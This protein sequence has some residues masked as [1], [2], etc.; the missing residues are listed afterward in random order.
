MPSL[1]SENAFGFKGRIYGPAI[2]AFILIGFYYL[3][4]GLK[5]DWKFGVSAALALS[6]IAITTNFMNLGIAVGMILLVIINFK[7]FF[8]PIY[9]SVIGILIVCGIVYLQSSLVP[10]LVQTKLKYVFRPWEYSSLRIRISDLQKAFRSENFTTLENI[11]GKGFGASTRI[12][13]DNKI[14]V[15]FRGY[16]TFQEI[17]NGFYY[18]FHR[19]GVSLMTIFLLSHAYLTYRIPNLKAK[20]GFILMFIMTNLLSIHYFNYFFYLLIPFVILTKDNQEK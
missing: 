10:E 17:D 19:G 1:W 4:R 9:F 11:F 2:T 20:L 3:Y 5:F 8:N 6:Y 7:R 14:A 13:R 16:Y 15:S 12:F 18:I